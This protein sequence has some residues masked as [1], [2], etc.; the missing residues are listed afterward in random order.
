L[1]NGACQRCVGARWWL[2][3]YAPRVVSEVLLVARGGSLVLRSSES[4]QAYVF[5][6]R[7]EENLD[8]SFERVRQRAALM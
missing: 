7:A 6:W 5:F 4:V 1:P 8:W 3:Q 2:I